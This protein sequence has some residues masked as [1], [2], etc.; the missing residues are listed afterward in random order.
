MATL[1]SFTIAAA[2]LVAGTSLAV[3]QYGPPTGGQPPAATGAPPGPGV[4]PHDV[5]ASP[6][7]QS[8]AP[9]T[10]AAAGTR[11]APTTRHHRIYMFSRHRPMKTG[12][13]LPKQPQ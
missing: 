8:A 9:P 1:K 13:P 10:G 2:L 5:T 12:Q 6:N 7:R 3:A 11:I 4:I